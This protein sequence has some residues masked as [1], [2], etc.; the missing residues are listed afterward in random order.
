MSENIV[1]LLVIGVGGAVGSILRYIL[2]GLVQQTVIA[3]P[4][5]TL[6]VNV[7]GCLAVGFLSERLSEVP[8]DPLYRTGILI[9]VLGGFTTFSTFS[10]ET[11]KL[12]EDRQ[13][14]L[15]LLNVAAS[16]LTCLLAAWAGI[17]FARW[18]VTP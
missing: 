1:R 14:A 2:A 5:G 4:L 6:V 18:M 9:G 15:A 8:V 16:M 12:A 10:L 3:F 11:M 17:R 7:S 13:F